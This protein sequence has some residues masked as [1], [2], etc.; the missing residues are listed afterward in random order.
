MTFWLQYENQNEFISIII[1]LLLLFVL[2]ILMNINFKLFK[3][4]LNDNVVSIKKI[5]KKALFSADF[6][7]I[8]K[9]SFLF[10]L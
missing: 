2:L 7:I 4:C 10:L 6:V 1:I 8:R 5:C 9:M 3:I